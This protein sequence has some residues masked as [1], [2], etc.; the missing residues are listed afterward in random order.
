MMFWINFT[1]LIIIHTIDMMLTEHYVGNLWFNETFYPMSMCIKHFSIHNALW[2]SRVTMYAS[3]LFFMTFR[4][5]AH[6]C[7]V[8]GIFNL[9]YWT[10]MLPWLFSLGILKW[11][12]AA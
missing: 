6:V 10:A 8:V 11:P 7:N 9:L 3:L 5:N 1:L 4:H 12:G 2:I